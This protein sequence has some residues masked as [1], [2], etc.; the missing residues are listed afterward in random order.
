[1]SQR[2]DTKVTQVANKP[3]TWPATSKTRFHLGTSVIPL[4][5]LGFWF[6]PS[7]D[8]GTRCNI[9]SSLLPVALGSIGVTP[10]YPKVDY[11]SFTLES[12]PRA[13][14]VYKRD[15][16]LTIADRAGAVACFVITS[17][18]FRPV[19]EI[20]CCPYLRPSVLI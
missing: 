7:S 4:Y 13:F 11:A 9:A 15:I 2:P 17:G 19:P 16:F 14:F 10:T 1:M 18:L 8:L 20:R 12:T 6:S 3:I 5:G